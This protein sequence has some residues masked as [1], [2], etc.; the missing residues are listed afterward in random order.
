MVY[1]SKSEERKKFE[2]K[3]SKKNR[4]KKNF[5]KTL[6][7]FNRIYN[8]LQE[9]GKFYW[10]FYLDALNNWDEE[11]YDLKRII[12]LQE[13]RIFASNIEV[14]RQSGEKDWNDDINEEMLTEALQ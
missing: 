7:N 10:D 11:S 1:C 3:S 8:K 12:S 9:E 13:N 6:S 4:T 2:E 14:L 5:E